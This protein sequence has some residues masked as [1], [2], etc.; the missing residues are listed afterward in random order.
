M[1]IFGDPV[2]SKSESS[3]TAAFPSSFFPTA[4]IS[5]KQWTGHGDKESRA[6]VKVS[7][8]P[9]A[10]ALYQR[11]AE[12]TIIASRVGLRGQGMAS[13]VRVNAQTYSTIGRSPGRL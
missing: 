12:I 9:I 10:G 7:F 5:R 8:L 3:L 4:L 13:R 6:R 2:R 11:W 1:T